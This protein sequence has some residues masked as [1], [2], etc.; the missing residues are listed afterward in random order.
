VKPSHV[1]GKKWL[2]TPGSVWKSPGDWPW[3]CAIYAIAYK[4]RAGRALATLDTSPNHNEVRSF[5]W[6]PTKYPKWSNV[7]P[8]N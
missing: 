8:T 5:A 1:F 6:L 7:S 3:P 4:I 2:G